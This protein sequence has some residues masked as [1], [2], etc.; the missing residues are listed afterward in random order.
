MSKD[1]YNRGGKIPTFDGEAKNF[2]SWWKKYLTY[3]KISKFKDIIKD[4][5]D[6]DIVEELSE[7]SEEMAKV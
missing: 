5:R 3:A 1:M 6:K 2:V 4:N 7:D